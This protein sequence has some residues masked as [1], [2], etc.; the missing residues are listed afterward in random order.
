MSKKL[1]AVHRTPEDDDGENTNTFSRC[2]FFSL[3][4]AKEYAERLESEGPVLTWIESAWL[5][6]EEN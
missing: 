6:D 4:K 1:Y 2:V 5:M 3:E